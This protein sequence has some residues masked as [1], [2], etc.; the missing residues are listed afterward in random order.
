MR[1][2]EYG[3]TMTR[4]Q[5]RERRV[6]SIGRGVLV[7]A[8]TCAVLLGSGAAVSAQ[9][10]TRSGLG[11]GMTVTEGGLSAVVPP[12]GEG[13]GAEAWLAD[14]G[15]IGLR[16]ETSQDGRVVVTSDR[17]PPGAPARTLPATSSSLRLPETTIQGSPPPCQDSAYH[18]TAS[19]WRS[20]VHWWFRA[21][22]TPS[23]LSH[24]AAQKAIK[25][26]ASHITN[27]YNDCGRADHVSATSQ[28]MGVTSVSPGIGSSSA[29]QNP[30]GRNVVGF[31]T[32]L[33]SELGLTCWWYRGSTTVEAD[34]KLNK[35][36]FNWTTKTAGCVNA[37]V[38]QAVATHEFGHVFGLAHVSEANH[39]NLTMSTSMFACD[40]S[41]STLGL[42]DMLGLE[43][44]Y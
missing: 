10:P 44:R 23:N 20:T 42:G 24:Y 35:H 17:L 3:L 1:W 26:G 40:D 29:C 12:R 41:P 16:I 2:L 19:W 11:P 7:A 34:M 25:S 8:T 5:H 32:L 6:L 37:Y 13:V 15:S 36:D 18:L 27:A 31:G 9:G 38:V 39:G 33:G 30:D 28:F 22:S 14:G 43:A 4:A 21:S